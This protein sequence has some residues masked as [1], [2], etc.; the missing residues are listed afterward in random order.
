MSLNF[1]GDRHGKNCRDTHFSCISKFVRDES[2]V[3]Q[4]RTSQ[5]IVSSII[6]RQEKSNENRIEKGNLKKSV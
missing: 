6:S 5:D 3:K 2:L 4:I 1:F